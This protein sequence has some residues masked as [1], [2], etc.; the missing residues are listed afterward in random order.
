VGASHSPG[1][2]VPSDRV[3]SVH[4]AFSIGLLSTAPLAATRLRAAVR[5]RATFVEFADAQALL[6]A[7]ARDE[8][9]LTVIE[10]RGRDAQRALAA[11]RL[12]LDSFPLHPIVAWC[13]FRT[14]DARDVLEVARLG[15]R[16]LLREDADDL[17]YTLGNAVASAMQRTVSHRIATALG[18]LV[19]K[20]L[21]PVLE[22]A[23]EHAGER[24]D[25]DVVAAAF[26]VS[27]RTLHNRL[28][29]AGLPPTRTFL[30]WCRLL[31][32]T[33]LLEQPGYT[34]DG[35]A[36]QLDYT[37][38]NALSASLRRYTGSGIATLRREGALVAT[39]EAFRRT[40]REDVVVAPFSAS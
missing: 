1:D 25:R 10:L 19:P 23:L 27:R 34:L 39:A 22:Y 24:L 35:V 28:I 7:L 15:V 33:A 9:G 11:L 32:A 8:I 6:A 13:D 17:P 36:G 2:V 16:D 14:I 37:D 20:R 40:V 26:G 12:V 30:T 4:V 21:L 38:G 31:V 18:E 5:G 3:G 29:A